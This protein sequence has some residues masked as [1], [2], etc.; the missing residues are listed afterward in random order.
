MNCNLLLTLLLTIT[1]IQCTDNNNNNNIKRRLTDAYYSDE[2]IE[3]NWLLEPYPHK[4]DSSYCNIDIVSSDITVEYFN[5]NYL[6]KKPILI[7]PTDEYS[8]HHI[9]TRIH[10]TKQRIIQQYGNNSITLGTV[11]S[12]THTGQGKLYSYILSEYLYELD[13]NNSTIRNKYYL[14]DR[15]SFFQSSY[16]MLSQHHKHDIFNQDTNPLY[17]SVTTLA[18][19][20]T[21][22]GINY[23]FHKDG[24]NEVIF[25]RKRW[26]FYPYNISIPY[27]YNSAQTVSKWYKQNYH[28]IEQHEK[29]FECTQYPGEIM[30]VPEGWYHATINIGQTIAIAG[31]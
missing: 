2:T 30:Y 24:W 19:G 21:G 23:H 1:T 8:K 18:I 20:G 16:D 13:N 5:N 9:N 10:W 4:Y 27:G 14:F 6:Y 31:K 11:S 3:N 26:F 15:S 12:L 25:G 7:V 28:R 22:S 17:D 29:P